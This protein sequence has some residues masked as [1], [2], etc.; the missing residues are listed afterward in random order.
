MSPR[1]LAA[2]YVG[3]S[4]IA[5]SLLGV[6]VWASP[7]TSPVAAADRTLV[8][9][10]FLAV[11]ALGLSSAVRPNWLRRRV[12]GRTHGARDGPGPAT[13]PYRGHHPDCEHFAGHVLRTGGRVLCA[14]CTGLGIGAVAAIPLMALHAALPGGLPVGPPAAVFALGVVLVSLSYVEVS[15]RRGHAGLHV[16][17]NALLVL[18]FLFLT[19]GT[20]EATGKVAYG[21]LAVLVSLLMVDTRIR[22]SGWRHAGLRR[23]CGEACGVPRTPATSVS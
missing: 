7:A 20:F 11:A 1:G 22:L 5:G 14:G 19:V 2:Y 17:A 3:L 9:A 21:L 18:G 13:R 4:A 23:Q 8:G 15:V 12:S 10:A 16:A 6:V